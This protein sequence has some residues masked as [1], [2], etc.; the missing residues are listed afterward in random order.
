MSIG[1]FLLFFM[2]L[3][4]EIISVHK[5]F[6]GTLVGRA[7]DNISLVE[8]IA[9]IFFINNAIAIITLIEMALL[10]KLG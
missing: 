10:K 4:Q 5:Q 9:W 1:E 6:W 7:W 3:M 8:K 2:K